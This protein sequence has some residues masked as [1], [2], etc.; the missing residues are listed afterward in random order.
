MRLRWGRQPAARVP[1][2]SALLAALHPDASD[3]S[4][5]ALHACLQRV[6]T[7][8]VG[9]VS[10]VVVED[11]WLD[12]PDAFCVIYRPPDGDRSV[13]LRRHR[14][15]A[16][17]AVAWQPGDLVLRYDVGPGDVPEPAPFAWNVAEGDLANPLGHLAD[18]LRIDLKGVGWWGTLRRDLPRRPR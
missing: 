14:D 15:D 13:G 12:G 11:A 9:R 16:R 4:E 7:G 8:T 6:M 1:A 18:A 10:E 2:V 3:W 17:D 5:R